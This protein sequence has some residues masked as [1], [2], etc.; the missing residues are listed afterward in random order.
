MREIIGMSDWLQTPAGQYLLAWEQAQLRAAVTDVFGFHALQLGLPNLDVLSA[1]RMPHRWVAADRVAAASTELA[2]Q[3]SALPF[4]EQSLDLVVLPHTLELDADPHGVLREVARVLV[5]EGRVVISG[6]NPMSLWG[7]AQKRARLYQLLGFGRSFLPTE[8]NALGYWRLRDWLRLLNLE[9]D[10]PNSH[11]GCFRPAMRSQVWLD[12]F[13]FADRMGKRWWPI[14]GSVY[15]LVAV[16]R[17]HGM[18]LHSPLR[19]T[20][21]RVGAAPVSVANR[22]HRRART[23]RSSKESA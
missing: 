4:P 17:V 22:A 21:P 20:K 6:F 16:K 13:G 5:P 1:N 9:L 18:T 15:M 2:C 7:Q 23:A 8:V 3:F 14:L 12:R 10:S 19:A 11:F